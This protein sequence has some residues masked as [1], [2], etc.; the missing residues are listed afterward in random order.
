MLNIE[1][2]DS[3]IRGFVLGKQASA[4]GTARAEMGPVEQSSAPG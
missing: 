4:Q 1:L 3:R 2:Q